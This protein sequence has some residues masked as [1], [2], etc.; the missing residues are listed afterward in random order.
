MTFHLYTEVTVT[1]TVTT[2]TITNYYKVFRLCSYI[3]KNKP[4]RVVFSE[5]LFL[6]STS[7][8]HGPSVH[9]GRESDVGSHDIIISPLLS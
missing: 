6:A 3:K 7:W 9:V 4:N 5:L 2:Q 8:L 1:T